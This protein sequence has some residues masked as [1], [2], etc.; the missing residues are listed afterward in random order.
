MQN[1]PSNRTIETNSL[2]EPCEQL[3]YRTGRQEDVTE[4]ITRL[5]GAMEE[6]KSRST[7]CLRHDM[8]TAIKGKG[9]E[10][11]IFFTLGINTL[12]PLQNTL[13]KQLQTQKIAHISD[14]MLFQIN[15][16]EDNVLIPKNSEGKGSKERHE[17]KKLSNSF[18]FPFELNLQAFCTKDIK[19]GTKMELCGVIIHDGDTPDSGHYF[20]FLKD[21]HNHWWEYNDSNITK[22]DA[23]S[24]ARMNKE[25]AEAF[26]K[27][28]GKLGN[29]Q[30]PYV[31]LYRKT[32]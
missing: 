16:F 21:E 14:Y 25:T 13:L 10:N 18:E 17:T 32:H 2:E 12:S 7:A 11:I 30:N 29:K 15:R 31:L 8:Q 23:L 6:E 5:L 27:S 19:D 4:F 9:N 22:V 3:G 26:F 20:V 24:S 1:P 28:A